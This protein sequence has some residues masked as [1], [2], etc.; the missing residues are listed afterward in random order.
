[1]KA[2]IL[3]VEDNEQLSE[4]NRCYL[5]LEGFA[6]K[7]AFTIAQARA[8]LEESE[9]DVI[10][11]DVMLPDGDGIDFCREIYD[12][13][14][15]QIIFLTAKV[16]EEDQIKGFEAGGSVYLTK[17]YSMKVMVSCIESSLRKK[18]TKAGK[19]PKIIK[20]GALSLHLQ[21]SLA[22]WNDTDLLLS[23]KEFSVLLFLVRNHGKPVTPETLY[24]TVWKA[25]LA[26]DRN[27][28]WRHMSCLKRKL[29]AVC[30]EKAEITYSRTAGYVLTVFENA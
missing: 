30:G 16:S 2:E 15:A 29:S 24:E 25:P 22:L 8:A 17:P 27:S 23:K 5:E 6:V 20:I 9:P 11:L 10:L 1:M 7:T 14:S 12:E 3:L 4:M 21:S 28:L 19:F 18:N 26:G 13:T